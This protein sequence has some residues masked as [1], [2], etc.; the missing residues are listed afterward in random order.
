MG[1]C[2][3]FGVARA[4]REE[5]RGSRQPRGGSK[6]SRADLGK[7]LNSKMHTCSLAYKIN[8]SIQDKRK[9][10]RWQKGRWGRRRKGKEE[11]RVKAREEKTKTINNNKCFFFL[12]IFLLLHKGIVKSF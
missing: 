4:G 8:T 7:L 12:P 1:N 5:V 2:Q 3:A 10:G 6:V 9:K 11:E